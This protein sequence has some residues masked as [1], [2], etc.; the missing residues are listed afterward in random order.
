MVP[1]STTGDAVF[2]SS[3]DI[4]QLLKQHDIHDINVAY[5]ESVAQPLAS[6]EFLAPVNDLH[7]LKES[8]TSQI[9][10]PPHLACPLPA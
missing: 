10:S 7:T 6:P 4:L 9:G 1:D 3:Q 8:R 2:E 5:H